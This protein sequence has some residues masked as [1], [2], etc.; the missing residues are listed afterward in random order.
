M[1]WPITLI[2]LRVERVADATCHAGKIDESP[3][4]VQQGDVANVCEDLV[5]GFKG[6]R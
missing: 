4:F 2:W 3:E 5:D 6:C 1:I